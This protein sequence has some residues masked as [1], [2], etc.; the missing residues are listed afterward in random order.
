MHTYRKS[1]HCSITWL[2]EL[3]PFSWGKLRGFHL[4]SQRVLFGQYE[5]LG[6]ISGILTQKSR[7]SEKC[8]EGGGI[9]QGVHS[10]I[11]K[12]FI[13]VVDG[14][15]NSFLRCSPGIPGI[16]LFIKCYSLP[17]AGPSVIVP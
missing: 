9:K 11:Q 1:W 7:N 13:L 17:F 2:A 8:L 12:S 6:G 10:Q 16:F 4:I 5:V 15:F 3:K 14:A